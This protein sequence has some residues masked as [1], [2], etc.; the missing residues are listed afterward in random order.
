MST[1]R[2]GGGPSIRYST[3]YAGCPMVG[4]PVVRSDGSMVWVG[5]MCLG[6]PEG[7]RCPVVRPSLHECGESQQ[8]VLVS[9]VPELWVWVCHK[10]SVRSPWWVRG[11]ALIVWIDISEMRGQVVPGWVQECVQGRGG[12][13]YQDEGESW[14]WEGWWG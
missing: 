8:R 3:M 4:C 12:A 13:I 1:V 7:L 10:F 14:I 11:C 6:Q 2:P 5:V 9:W